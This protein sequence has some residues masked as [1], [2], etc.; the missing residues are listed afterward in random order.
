MGNIMESKLKYEVIEGWEKLPKGYV[1]RD[2][3]GVT[4]APNDRVYLITRNDS[5]VIVYDRDG[6]FVSSWGD[7]VLTP[8]THCI[9]FGP[10][11]SVYTV[12]DGDH[13]I[14]KFT[15]DGKQLMILGTPGVASDTGYNPELVDHHSRLESITRGGPPFN[16][17]TGVAITSNSEV[18]VSD[19]YGNAR[20][21]HFSADG[22]LIRSWGEPGIKPGQFNLPHDICI[23]ADGR[24]LVADR[25]NDRIQIF[26]P[27]GDF[28]DQ[29]THVQR[30]TGLFIDREGLVYVSE[31]WRRVG[32]RSF[33]HG[34]CEK[35]EPG[36]VSV[37]DPKGKVLARWG[38]SDR[39]APGNFCAPHGI[40]ADSHGDIYVAE[41]TFTV[42]AKAGLVPPDC[43]T[44]QKFARKESTH[45]A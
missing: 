4:V 7:G 19:G 35:D 17:P 22:R 8:R 5:R 21:H 27:D 32:Q 41:V 25:E 39:C 10:D 13:T 29:W 44:F 33:V 11:G 16:R 18:Y 28:L 20:V 1:H 14:R 40:C 3:S 45:R 23:T 37:L 6:S 26:S 9:R 34:V 38:G 30:P 2:V 43:H 12:D 36:R 31:L 24:L 42:A 15:P